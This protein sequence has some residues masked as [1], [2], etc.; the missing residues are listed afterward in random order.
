MYFIFSFHSILKYPPPPP[1][2]NAD[3]S[4]VKFK[5]FYFCAK[6]KMFFKYKIALLQT[7][8]CNLSRVFRNVAQPNLNPI[9][10]LKNVFQYFACRCFNLKKKEEF[11]DKFL[12]LFSI[13]CLFRLLLDFLKKCKS[14]SVKCHGQLLIYNSRPGVGH[15]K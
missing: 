6:K 13:L 7:I 2:L 15:L 11:L 5:E 4:V 14:G 10:W 1:P 3:Q 9:K 12:C 8:Y